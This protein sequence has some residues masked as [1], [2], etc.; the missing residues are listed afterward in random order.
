MTDYELRLT[1]HSNQ[2]LHHCLEENDILDKQHSVKINKN[3]GYRK[4][5]SLS[6]DVHGKTDMKITSLM[7]CMLG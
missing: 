1:Q 7:L 5:P 4:S 3:Y 6:R 2:N